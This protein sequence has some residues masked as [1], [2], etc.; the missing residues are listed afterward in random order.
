VSSRLYLAIVLGLTF[1]VFNPA[2][3]GAQDK[4]AQLRKMLGV[5]E[6]T[7]ITVSLSPALPTTNPLKVAL[8]FGL[9]VG[10]TKNFVMWVTQWNKSGD[11]K[12]YGSIE[13]VQDVATAE[14]VLVRFV[15]RGMV[16]G[17]NTSGRV[18]DYGIVAAGSS[19]SSTMVPVYAYILNKKQSSYDVVGGYED[20]TTSS[21]STI[22]GQSLWDEMKGLMKG[23][24]KL[25]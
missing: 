18:T 3:S 2:V 23:R 22:A 9:D 25:K 16:A 24:P 14:V 15:N 1:L 12:K 13:L 21:A 8:A 7:P 20:T 5:S 10:V 6:E 4:D 19:S 17:T 11:A